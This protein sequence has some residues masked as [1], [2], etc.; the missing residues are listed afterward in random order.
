MEISNDNNENNSEIIGNGII[1]IKEN[2]FE[3]SS[4]T[5]RNTSKKIDIS[6]INTSGIIHKNGKLIINTSN[7]FSTD[8]NNGSDRIVNIS[9]LD[10]DNSNISET[11]TKGN[12]DVNVLNLIEQKSNNETTTQ[13]Y[14]NA[15]ASNENVNLLRKKKKYGKF[16]KNLMIIFPVCLICGLSFILFYKIFS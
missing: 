10:I 2:T 8:R 9:S 15:N 12:S 13:N 5:E 11:H 3:Q 6:E 4:L 1:N 7:L 16:C 14:L